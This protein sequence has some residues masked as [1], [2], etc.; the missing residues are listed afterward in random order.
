MN[1][2]KERCKFAHVDYRYGKN[3]RRKDTCKYKHEEYHHKVSKY[4]ENNDSEKIIFLCNTFLEMMNNFQEALQTTQINN[5][6]ER[7]VTEV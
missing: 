2:D 5:R 3:C 7:Q 6:Q 1:G 4:D